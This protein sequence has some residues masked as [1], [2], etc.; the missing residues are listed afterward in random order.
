MDRRRMPDGA[1]AMTR[2]DPSV[3]LTPQDRAALWV[4]SES[5]PDFTCRAAL[6]GILKRADLAQRR[7]ELGDQSLPSVGRLADIAA[8]VMPTPPIGIRS[9][10]HR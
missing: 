4:A 1:D 8:L 5:V 6:R 2:P 9:R 10:T 7:G 3:I